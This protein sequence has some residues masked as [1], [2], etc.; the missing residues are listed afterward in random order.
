VYWAEKLIWQLVPEQ[1]HWN[2]T[3]GMERGEVVAH[4]SCVLG[5]VIFEVRLGVF[6]FQAAADSPRLGWV[7]GACSYEQL[8]YLSAAMVGVS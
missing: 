5:L 8:A 2:E 4:F 3:G 1:E 7:G 6:E